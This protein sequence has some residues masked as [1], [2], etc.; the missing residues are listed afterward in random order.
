VGEG[1]TDPRLAFRH[2]FSILSKAGAGVKEG[3]A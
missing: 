1:L 3:F 2:D